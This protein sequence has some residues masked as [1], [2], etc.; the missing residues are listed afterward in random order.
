MKYLVLNENYFNNKRKKEIPF[1]DWYSNEDLTKLNKKLLKKLEKNIICKHHWDS[2]SKKI[3]DHKFLIKL[4]NKLLNEVTISINKFHNLNYSHKYW[5]IILLP[6]LQQLTFLFYDRWEMI[7]KIPKTNLIF[8]I[9]NYN[10]SI[11]FIPEQFGDLNAQNKDFNCW[12]VSKIVEYKKN[13]KFI[14]KNA[15]LIKKYKFKPNK[16]YKLLKIYELIFKM[17]SKIFNCNFFMHGMGFSKFETLYLNF[18]LSQFPFFWIDPV[19]ENKKVNIEKRKKYF[20][21]KS[22]KK[23]FENF[24]KQMIYLTIPKDYLENYNNIRN[25]ID[26]SYWPKKNKIILTAYSY[27]FNEIFKIWVAGMVEKGSKYLILQHGGSM[28]LAAFNLE[29]DVQ[30]DLS[31]KFLSWGWKDKVK[32]IIPFNAFVLSMRKK[33]FFNISAKKI[34]ICITLWNKFSI[35]LFSFPR[36][37][38]DRLRKINSIKCLIDNLNNNLSDKIVLRYVKKTE[39]RFLYKFQEEKFNKRIKY[40]RADLPFH[41]VTSKG[42]LFI[43]DSNSTGFLETMFYNLPT[44]LILDKKCDTFRKTNEKLIKLLERKKIIHYDANL[45]AKFINANFNNIEKWWFNKD[46]QL[47]RKKFCLKFV[48]KTNNPVNELKNVLKKC[49]NE[50]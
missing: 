1:Y 2:K 17:F 4:T 46:L 50:N 3:K 26:K 28:G 45:A 30:I 15:P 49:L 41:K 33:K 9:Y 21:K 39:K 29:V 47:I 34:F 31:H 43:H 35:G 7:N 13:I 48:K 10:R 23:D 44:I 11:D 6:W 25:A 22:N 42:K 27:K 16:K 8:C 18:K 12:I 5:K 36:T 40:D 20:Y 19:Y 14:K 32:K 37:N 24:V 38:L